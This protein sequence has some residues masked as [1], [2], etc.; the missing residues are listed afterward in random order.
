MNIADQNGSPHDEP[1][2]PP[3]LSAPFIVLGSLVLL[4]ACVSA[5]V[6]YKSGA[7][8]W[9]LVWF[10]D[11]RVSSLAIALLVESRWEILALSLAA[12]NLAWFMIRAGRHEPADE[13]S[14]Q[15]ADPHETSECA[16]DA[17]DVASEHAPINQLSAGTSSHGSADVQLDI[18]TAELARLRRELAGTK[19]QLDIASNAKSRFLANMSHEMRTPMN[20]IMGMTD[21]LLA[22][23]LP[24]REH[25][26]V[27]S[28]AQSSHTLL[29]IISDLLDFSRIESGSLQL[30]RGRFRIHEVVEDVCA[31]HA[32]SAHQKGIELMC[33]VDDNVPRLADGDANRIRQVLDNLL[34]N[35]IAYTESGEIVVRMTLVEDRGKRTLYRCDVQD[36][37]SG[38]SPELQMAMFDS[39]RGSDG[40]IDREHSGVG[41]G[42]T[43][44]RE[45]VALM[46]GSV[47]LRSRLGEGTR[48]GFSV[49]LDNV[50]CSADDTGERRV[51]RGARVLVVDDNETNRTILFHQLSGWGIVADTVASGAAALTRLRACTGTDERYDMLVLDLHMPGMD[52]VELARQIRADP[53][54][55]GIRSLM[56]T[57]ALLDLDEGEL[58]ELGID[59]YLSK[60]PRQSDLH[61][62]LLSLLPAGGSV[63]ESVLA[64][65][66]VAS[67]TAAECATSDLSQGDTSTGM[68]GSSKNTDQTPAPKTALT[69]TSELLASTTAS[70]EN[71]AFKSDTTSKINPEAIESIRRLQRPGKPDLVGRVLDIYL[72]RTPEAI[73]TMRLAM[74]TDDATALRE[75]AHSLK[76]SSAYVGAY[77]LSQCCARIE[78]ATG[79]G[80]LHELQNLVDEI[81][82]DYVQVM[83]ELQ[84]VRAA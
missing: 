16:T 62:S 24:T 78:Q 30:E 81:E 43:V 49:E 67:E 59:H 60:P 28:I 29:S 45:L 23:D 72:A 11:G 3:T 63:H 74:E 54:L 19:R 10:E 57:S 50:D 5:L 22:G 56:L 42:L 14:R 38:I 27:E 69:S 58:A 17:E 41:L 71:S 77:S 76:S 65:T 79:E 80:R 13:A 35:A 2:E 31:V 26:F 39:F 83:E 73:A 20:G 82:R 46:G 64:S 44:T 70:D 18:A 1:D 37:G 48:F 21:L 32:V 8:P 52:G 12:V 68:P 51:V 47:T 7:Y 53:E 15:S 40:S 34:R 33:Y 4:L 25:R 55:S 9:E 6:D 61:E 36:T 66:G 84:L 75:E